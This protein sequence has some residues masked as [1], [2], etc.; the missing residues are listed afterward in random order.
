M[1]QL[2]E[3][4][5]RLRATEVPPDIVSLPSIARSTRVLEGW[6][7]TEASRAGASMSLIRE[8]ERETNISISTTNIYIYIY[9]YI[10]SYKYG[11]Q[12][13]VLLEAWQLSLQAS[14]QRARCEAD[15]PPRQ[16]KGPPGRSGKHGRAPASL[17][18]SFRAGPKQDRRQ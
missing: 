4:E 5:S 15:R 14:A 16:R 6:D 9:I 2:Q 12:A 13:L 10:N 11:V 8:R 1:L 7:Q 18:T 3:S 17:T